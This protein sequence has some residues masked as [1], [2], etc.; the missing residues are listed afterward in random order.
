MPRLIPLSQPKIEG[1]AWRYVKECLDGEWVSSVGAFVGRFEESVRAYTGAKAATAAVNGTAGLHAALK[2]LGV[3]RGDRVAVPALTFIATA[4]AVRYT[5][6]EPVFLDCE[7]RRMN[8][9]LDALEA[10]LADKRA[11]K[12]KAVVPVHVLGYPVDM[13]RLM[14]LARRHRLLVVEDAAESLGSF[15]GGRHTGTFGDLGVLSFNGNK[16]IT[17]GGGGMILARTAGAGKRLK[18]LTQQAKYHPT[19]YLH[20]EVGFN[21]RLTNVLGALGLSQMERLGAFLAKRRRIA[22]WYRER[23]SAVPA[24]PE[25]KG[26]VWN[27]WLLG[28]RVPDARAKTRLLAAL[29]DAGCQ[30]RPLWVPVPLQPAYRGAKASIPNAKVAYDTVINIPSSTCVSE[31]DVDRVCR[32]L[33]RAP[34]TELLL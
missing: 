17:C 10:R 24:A 16:L 8:L 33:R 18:H 9:D 20:D 27:R 25:E 29:N 13:P 4:N 11:P 28:V 3:G 34:L 32:V 19:E 31:A 26:A 21:Y 7:P 2:A 30:S 22:S 1:N 12:L 23:L 14:R 15:I 5:G 6:A